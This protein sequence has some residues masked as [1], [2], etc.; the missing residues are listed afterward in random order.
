MRRFA[1]FTHTLPFSVYNQLRFRTPT[2]KS[3]NEC[4]KVLLP[5]PS[6]LWHGNWPLLTPAKALIVQYSY[7]GASGD[8]WTGR[9]N[10][11]DKSI[12]VS[13]SPNY[14]SVTGP[15]GRILSPIDIG[16]FSTTPIVVWDLPSSSDTFFQ[17]ASSSLFSDIF[18]SAA[19]WN[20]LIVTGTYL[21]NPSPVGGFCP[22]GASA[23]FQNQPAF[24][25]LVG[26]GGT[27]TF[28]NPASNPTNVPGPLPLFGVGAA[29]GFSRKLRKRIKRSTTSE[30]MSAIG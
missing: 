3:R 30:I 28:S 6:W 7:N 17:V 27:I 5:F 13:S 9:F 2:T 25:T 10:V 26:S 19:T 22:N 1:A 12:A 24:P 4:S 29:F 21:V 8:S 18:T 11:I 20:D 15:V 14:T 16:G 23:C